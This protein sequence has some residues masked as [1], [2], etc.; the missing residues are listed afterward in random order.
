MIAQHITDGFINGMIDWLSQ[1]CYLPLKLAENRDPVSPGTVLISPTS[2]HMTIDFGGVVK[3]VNVD[4]SD[5]Y[6]PSVN[7]LFESV[8]NVYSE[9]AIGVILTGMGSDGA[10]GLKL[11][12]KEGGLTIAQDEESCAVYGMPKAAVEYGAVVKISKIDE[13]SNLLLE[14]VGSLIKD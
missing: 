10:Q 9:K 11:I 1:Y 12:R 6:K 14:A 8:A 2:K 3:L 13:I 7:K 4:E 5:L